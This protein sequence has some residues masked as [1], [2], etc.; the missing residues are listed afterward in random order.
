MILKEIRRYGLIVGLVG[1]LL[2]G[3]VT[4]S[5]E[6][7]CTYLLGWLASNAN[8][9]IN[10]YFLDTSRTKNNVTKSLT[11]FLLRMFIYMLVLAISYKWTGITGMLTAFVGCLSIRIAILIYGIKGGIIDGYNK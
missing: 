7:I 1:L 11:G 4:M 3:L 5:I 9:Y 6:C 8:L 10:D 2:V